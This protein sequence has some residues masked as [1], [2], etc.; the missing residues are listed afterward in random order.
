M[1]ED[2]TRLA[3]VG[4]TLYATCE[5]WECSSL[6][7]IDAADPERPFITSQWQLPDGVTAAVGAQNRVYLLSRDNM[8]WAM[9]VSNPASPKII[10]STSRPG[11]FGQLSVV[12]NTLYLSAN[13]AGLIVL[14][15]D[16]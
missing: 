2:A 1:S 4:S 7:V 10:G 16:P 6:T 8:I 14:T 12:D 13:S 5:G 9:D 11:W 3:V 15:V